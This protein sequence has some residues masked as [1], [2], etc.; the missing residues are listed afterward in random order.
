MAVRAGENEV[1]AVL[2]VQVLDD[3]LG[4]LVQ[5]LGELLPGVRSGVVEHGQ[6]SARKGLHGLGVFG[7]DK[8]A[9]ALQAGPAGLKFLVGVGTH[10]I[11]ALHS[12]AGLAQLECPGG[13]SGILGI[14]VEVA[15]GEYGILGFIPGNK[16]VHQV[17]AVAFQNAAGGGSNHIMNTSL[18]QRPAMPVL[19]IRRSI[20]SSMA[21]IRRQA[22]EYAFW[23]CIIFMVSSFRSTPDTPSRL[24]SRS[25]SEV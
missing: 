19:L 3:G 20:A 6:G 9:D 7:V 16:G 12:H 18:R 1:L 4:N 8:L 17:T 23:Y 11:L 13:G 22:A 24:V 15:L 10:G 21:V 5:G 14:G 2:L 25:M